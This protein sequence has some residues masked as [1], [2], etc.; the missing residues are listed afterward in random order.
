MHELSITQNILDI[1]LKEA[2]KR[3]AGAIKKISLKIGEFTNIAPECIKF[4]FEQISKESPAK[5]ASLEI[6]TI[7]LKIKCNICNEKSTPE[8]HYFFICP[9]CQ[10]QNLEIISGKELLIE[11]IDIV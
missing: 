4:Y 10:G 2:E 5:D 6:E 3:K 9:K 8:E 11:S 1:C 7:P